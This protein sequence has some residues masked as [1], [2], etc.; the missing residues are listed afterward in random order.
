MKVE[1]KRG[2]DREAEK[3]L[4]GWTVDPHRIWEELMPMFKP[5]KKFCSYKYDQDFIR[6]IGPTSIGSVCSG[7]TV[8]RLPAVV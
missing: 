8:G 2:E 6:H 7:F 5:I 4:K 1:K 3:T